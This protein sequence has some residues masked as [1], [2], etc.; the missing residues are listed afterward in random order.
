MLTLKG[1][2]VLITRSKEANAELRSLLESRGARAICFPTIEITDPPTWDV[3]DRAIWKLAEYD[4]VCFTSK[5]AVA[6]FVERIRSIRP[7]AVDMLATRN[8]FAIGEKTK[9]SLESSGFSV[10]AS[11][12][13]A[14]AEELASLVQAHQIKG[15]KILFPKSNIAREHLPQQLRSMG[16]AVDEVIVYQTIVP[17]PENLERTRQ[18]FFENKIDVAAFFSPSSILNFS[19]MVGVD[20]FPHTSIAVIGSTTAETVQQLGLAAVI[21]AEHATAESL[22]ESIEKYFMKPP[23][24]DS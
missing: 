18:L 8:I 5:N 24:G 1:K 16:A 14:S 23:L 3:C 9:R 4:G 13:H 11:P 17:E 22:V 12:Q 7:Q 20:I 10:L 2:T 6:K 19:E 15:A 21:R